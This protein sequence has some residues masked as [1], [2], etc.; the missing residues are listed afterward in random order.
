MGVNISK[1]PDGLV[2]VSGAGIFSYSDLKAVQNAAREV[3]KAG[4]KARCLVVA[5]QFTGWGD[6]GDWGDLAFV[7]ESDHLI[8]MIAV[9]GPL[10]SKDQLM[11]FLGAGRRKAIV[12]FFLS[13]EEAAARQWLDSSNK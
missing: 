3:A 2:A 8:S 10:E 6:D 4:T 12:R 9:V 7:R 11:M 5:T 13:G 1:E